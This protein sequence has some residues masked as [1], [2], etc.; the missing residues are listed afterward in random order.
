MKDHQISNEP[1][2]DQINQLFSAGM[3]ATNEQGIV[4][5]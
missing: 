2:M 4:Q 1:L 3:L 5:V